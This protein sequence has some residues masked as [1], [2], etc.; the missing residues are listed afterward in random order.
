MEEHDILKKVDQWTKLEALEGGF[1]EPDGR[2]PYPR[3]ILLAGSSK[4][5]TAYFLEI[6]CLSQVLNP[7]STSNIYRLSFNIKFPFKVAPGLTSQTASLIALL[8]K[9]LDLPGFEMDE[10]ND[11][12]FYR[13]VLLLS[14]EGLN[15]DLILG[16]IGNIMLTVQMHIDPIRSVASGEVSYDELIAKT[17]QLLKQSSHLS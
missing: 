2:F 13:Y 1:F 12:L 4:Q 15:K 11:D 16:I 5:E 14:Q 7:E 10:A 6:T 9:F 17:L 8:N 3:L